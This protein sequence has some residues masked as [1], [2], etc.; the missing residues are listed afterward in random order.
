MDE[1]RINA[2]VE[3]VVRELMAARAQAAP[4]PAPPVHDTSWT[5]F[6]ASIPAP[7][8]T[9]AIPPAPT[10]RSDGKSAG[11][12]IDLPDPTTP[13]QRNRPGVSQ[14]KDR[15]A[16]EALIASTT[17]RIG[18]GRAGPRYRTS[19]LLLFQADHA[20]TQDALMRDVDQALLDELGLFTVQT[21]ITGGKQQYLLRPDLG[22][23]LSAEAKKTI[24]AKCI[25]SPN[26]QVCVGD[27]LSAAAIEANLRQIFPVLQQGAQLARLTLGTPFFIKYCR[28][29][30][31]NDVGEALHPDVAILLIGERPGL[32]RAESM[33]AY[34]AFRPKA[35]DSDADRDVVCNIFQNGGTNPLEAG[36]VVMQMAQKMIQHQASGVRLKLAA[37]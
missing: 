18:V 33:S 22:R 31:L 2:I 9:G 3:A 25:R 6:A 23:Q 7:A 36:A 8:P 34:M 20:V 19:S 35:G 13:E 5:A 12:C 21:N 1:A 4:P 15:D 24:A 14:P 10:T 37:K 30:V 27:G 11:L 29:G 16:L 26:I 28:V 32:G 17:A